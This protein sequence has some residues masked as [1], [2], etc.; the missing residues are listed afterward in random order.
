MNVTSVNS[1]ES[2]TTRATEAVAKSRFIDLTAVKTKLASLKDP[3][4]KTLAAVA[5]LVA[6]AVKP[7][8][9]LIAVTSFTAVSMGL[10]FYFMP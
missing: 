8:H 4:L 7:V 9:T 10:A 1:V 3:A 6:L 2:S 5:L